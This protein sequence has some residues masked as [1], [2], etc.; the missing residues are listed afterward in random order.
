MPVEPTSIYVAIGVPVLMMFIA[1]SLWF[2]RRIS[3]AKKAF[4]ISLATVVLSCAFLFLDSVV[5][6]G[7]M[8]AFYIGILLAIGV[9]IV[10]RIVLKSLE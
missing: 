2:S 1:G 8:I 7:R 4:A 10:L 9:G 3:H 5:G 6:L